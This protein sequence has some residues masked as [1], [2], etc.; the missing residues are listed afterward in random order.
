MRR[1]DLTFLRHHRALLF[2]LLTLE[3]VKVPLAS[4]SKVRSAWHTCASNEE[5]RHLPVGVEVS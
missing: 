3:S 1:L 5:F 2:D 4:R